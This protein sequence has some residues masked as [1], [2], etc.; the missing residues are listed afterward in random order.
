MTKPWNKYTKKEL[1]ELP[2]R[3]WECVSEYSSVLLVNTKMKHDSGFNLFAVIGCDDKGLPKEIAGY[4]DDFRL[5]N[6][7]GL[8]DII[9]HPY[10]IGIDCSMHGVFRIHAFSYNVV[11]KGNCSTTG[12]A[13]KEVEK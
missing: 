6:I 12:F 5:E 3:D 13:F 9:I 11:V 1:L 4:M 2:Q 8:E 10:N 7:K